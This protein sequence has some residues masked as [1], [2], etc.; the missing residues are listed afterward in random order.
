MKVETDLIEILVVI[1]AV[2]VVDVVAIV[3]RVRV[4]L[5]RSC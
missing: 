1:I 2:T 3:F 4:R 5:F